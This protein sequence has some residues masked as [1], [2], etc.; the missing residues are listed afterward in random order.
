[1]LQRQVFSSFRHFV[2]AARVHWQKLSAYKNNYENVHSVVVVF[3]YVRLVIWACCYCYMGCCYC[4][5]SAAA[6]A[7]SVAAVV[8]IIII[9]IVFAA[10]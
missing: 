4:A 8:I 9:F 7:A 10:R 3:V 6:A 5:A 2:N 1:M